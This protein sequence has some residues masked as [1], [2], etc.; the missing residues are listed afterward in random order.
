MR[1]HLLRGG[2]ID[3]D[4]YVGGGVRDRGERGLEPRLSA[5]VPET[6]QSI[7]GCDTLRGGEGAPRVRDA[8]QPRNGKAVLLG[9]LAQKRA[10]DL[11][12]SEQRD[13]DAGKSV[14]AGGGLSE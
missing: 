8:H 12:G 1:G 10:P 6:A 3:D 14:L 5:F 4:A 2:C 9:E 13:G 7:G 11:A